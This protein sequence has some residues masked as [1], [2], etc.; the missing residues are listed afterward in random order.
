MKQH[1]REYLI[2]RIR[3]G[4]YMIEHAGLMLT[5]KPPTIEQTLES[6]LVYAKS[7]DE[8]FEEGIMSEDDIDDWMLEKGLWTQ[9]DDKTIEG[10]KKDIETLKIKIYENRHKND[11]KEMARK[12]LRAAEKGLVK[13]YQK[14]TQFIANTC[15]GLAK[16]DQHR[17]LIRNCTFCDGKKFH[18]DDIILDE[19]ITLHQEEILGE[20]SIRELAR[21][22]PWKSLWAIR[23]HVNLD[24][25]ANTK[26]ELT[27]DQKNITVWS[28]M[29]DNI[30]EAAETPSD[31]VIEDDDVL[32]GWF[33]LQRRKRDTE[34]ATNDFESSTHNEKIKNS[35]E[36][37][38]MSHNREDAE[39]VDGMNTLHSKIVKKQRNALIQSR[40]EVGQD[41]FADERLGFTQRQNQMFKDKFKK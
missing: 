40:G 28:M 8:A 25:F 35:S 7:Y 26:S 36:I 27:V 12:Y 5:I 14:K 3:S 23:E 41:Q 6:N 13:Q 19:I 31:D 38:V 17:W 33:I 37:F 9:E 32:D 39:R 2:S 11:V 22:E 10:I 30:Q 34:K 1:A 4:L 20:S 16:T 24:L 15:E 29:Y 21:N 18:F